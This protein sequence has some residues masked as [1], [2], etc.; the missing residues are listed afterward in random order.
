MAKNHMDLETLSRDRDTFRVDGV[1]YELLASDDFSIVDQSELIRIGRKFK[2]MQ[3]VDIDEREAQAIADQLKKFVKRITVNLPDEVN[4]KLTD[5][6]RL[7]IVSAFM[8]A[9]PGIQNQ[10]QNQTSASQEK[11]QLE[12]LRLAVLEEIRK[13][14]TATPYQVK[15]QLR[16][17][18]AEVDARDQEIYNSQPTLAG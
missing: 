13:G 12:T 5:A 15:E 4:A 10:N 17:L 7:A 18:M 2:K 1:P 8:Q 6:Q 11:T 9:M 16:Q 14:H 3:E